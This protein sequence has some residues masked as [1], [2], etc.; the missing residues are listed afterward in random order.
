MSMAYT[1]YVPPPNIRKDLEDATVYR[2]TDRE[3]GKLCGNALIEIRALDKQIAELKSLITDPNQET[4]PI[5]SMR[6]DMENLLAR[7]REMNNG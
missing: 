2:R 6:G 1:P 7:L 5:S 3:L 4:C